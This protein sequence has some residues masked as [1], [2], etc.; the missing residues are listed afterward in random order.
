MFDDALLRDVVH[1][2]MK[3]LNFDVLKLEVT[4]QIFMKVFQCL[5]AFCEDNEA[6]LWIISVPAET[7][8][9]ITDD[10]KKLLIFLEVSGRDL[11]EFNGETFQRIDVSRKAFCIL[12][13]E[14]IHAIMNR[15][16]ARGR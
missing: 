14:T 13:L 16:K 8:L 2:A 9:G 1:G 15:L 5:N 12:F 11:L 4:L 7:E 6:I 10:T 3:G